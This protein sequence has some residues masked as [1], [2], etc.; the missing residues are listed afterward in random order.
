MSAV[1]ALRNFGWAAI[2]GGAVLASAGTL[3]A[4]EPVQEQLNTVTEDNKSLLDQIRE[5]QIPDD[6]RA[7]QELLSR[8]QYLIPLQQRQV[9]EE[10]VRRYPNT[11][12]AAIGRRLLE[13]FKLYD[14]LRHDER[15]HREQQTAAIRAFWDARRPPA[16]VVNANP[17][18]ITNH[19]AETVLFELQ[20][21]GMEWSDPLILRANQSVKLNYSARYRRLTPDGN[22]FYMLP[23]GGNFEFLPGPSG[24]RPVLHAVPR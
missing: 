15:L 17:L 3:A 5:E 9:A 21:P 1:M 14:Q 16:P 24:G 2:C 7:A 8:I 12:L 22:T 10:L 19:A 23:Q 20:G 6:E 11:Q 13:E 4:Q 18:T